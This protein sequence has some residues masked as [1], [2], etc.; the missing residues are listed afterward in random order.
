[1]DDAEKVGL[2]ISTL[3][4]GDRVKAQVLPDGRSGECLSGHN[5]TRGDSWSKAL[6]G[7]SGASPVNGPLNPCQG[8]NPV[9]G[10]NTH[11]SGDRLG[12]LLKRY[13]S[14]IAQSK[15]ARALSWETDG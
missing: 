9:R 1:M 10:N 12:M 15:W 6:N 3:H 2:D 13:A 8:E 5:S 7:N 4:S 14:G 11:C